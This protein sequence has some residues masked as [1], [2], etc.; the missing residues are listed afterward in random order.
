MH[1][2]ITSVDVAAIKF[3][4][5]DLAV[6]VF[7][8]IGLATGADLHA[9]TLSTASQLQS[10]LPLKIA[11][12][13]KQMQT[14]CEESAEKDIEVLRLKTVSADTGHEQHGELVDLTLRPPRGEAKR[15]NSPDATDKRQERTFG[16]AD[17]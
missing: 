5:D 1:L 2:S 11:R 4:V 16:A 10:Y 7:S 13:S 3:A 8:A 15:N 14:F 12:L 17:R 9:D 6:T